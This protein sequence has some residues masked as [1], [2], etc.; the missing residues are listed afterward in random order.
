MNVKSV[1]S[2]KSVNVDSD[3]KA[4]PNGLGLDLFCQRDQCEG[5]LLQSAEGTFALRL[6]SRISGGLV[7]SY[8]DH[9]IADL[10]H[11]RE[12]K[13]VILIRQKAGMYLC[14]KKTLSLHDIIRNFVKLKSLWT[15]HRHIPK[16]K[17]LM[18]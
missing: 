6:S 7:L 1:K 11:K 16:N 14:N 2:V 5:N 4:L 9:V 17:I 15:P 8:V 18:F 13:H 12:C 10:S 3:D